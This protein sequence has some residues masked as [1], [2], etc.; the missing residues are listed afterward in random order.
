[1]GCQAGPAPVGRHATG[2]PGTSDA[3]GANDAQPGAVLCRLLSG[4]AQE[5]ASG[6]WLAAQA[7]AA[8]FAFFSAFL[9]RALAKI[10][11]ASPGARFPS[12]SM[13]IGHRL[14]RGFDVQHVFL[15]RIAT[16]KS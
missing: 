11:L 6:A 16:A 4:A 12:A 14:Q 10:F 8:T 1:M 3:R 5:W 7:A 2:R 15:G 13:R 9:F